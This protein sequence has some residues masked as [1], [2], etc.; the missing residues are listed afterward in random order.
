MRWGRVDQGSGR[1]ASRPLLPG[2]L[3]P[4]A[5]ALLV[6]CVA[7]VTALGV[8]FAGTS[9]PGRLDA[10]VDGPIRSS[11]G[12]HPLPLDIVAL[13]GEP[14]L[15]VPLTVALVLA[16]A[17]AGRWRG[18]VLAAVAV[19]L[20]SALTEDVL[21]PVIGRTIGGALSYPSGHT[22]AAFT[23]ATIS[24]ILL[25][26]PPRPRLTTVA[27]RLLVLGGY[28]LAVAVAVAVIGLHYHYFTDTIGGAAVGTGTVL[29][30][31]YIID[32][33]L[34]PERFPPG[35]SAGGPTRRARQSVAGGSE[36]PD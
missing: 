14:V 25:A 15:V 10:A 5:A 28:L 20:A 4:A 21:K 12:G 6:A 31:A 36:D 18:A 17:V 11:L 22:T 8:R 34:P 27:R 24:A 2:R 26:Q 1:P 16:C 35:F 9:K 23:L 29:L 7:V 3:R 30:G 32:A 19:P 13:F 33:V